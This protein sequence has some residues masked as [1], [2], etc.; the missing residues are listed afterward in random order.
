MSNFRVAPPKSIWPIME[1]W[2]FKKVLA[3]AVTSAARRKRPLSRVVIFPLSRVIGPTVSACPFRS[4]SPEL[5]MDRRAAL[6][7]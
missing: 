3:N 6:A 1:G 2:G 4:S 5:R 7:I